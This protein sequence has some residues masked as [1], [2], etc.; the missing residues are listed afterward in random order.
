MVSKSTLP[1]FIPSPILCTDNAA[2]IASCGYY[3]I[4]KGES[5]DL[6]LDVKP[7]AMIQQQ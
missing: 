6:Y 5:S 7:N 1:V 3:H 2:M 4:K